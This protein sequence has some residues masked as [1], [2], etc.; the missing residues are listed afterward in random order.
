M[1]SPD[2]EYMEELELQITTLKSALREAKKYVPREQKSVH[3]TINAALGANEIQDTLRGLAHK[4][5]IERT[6]R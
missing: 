2:D 4:L 5:S 6:S 3:S 1:K